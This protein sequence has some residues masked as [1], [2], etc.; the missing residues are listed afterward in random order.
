MHVQVDT[1]AYKIPR[2]IDKLYAAGGYQIFI[3]LENINS[4]NLEASKKRQNRIEDY[5]EMILA[6]KKYP[7]II[8]CGYIIGFPNDT[9]ES[10]LHDVEVLKR[11]L[12]IDNIYLNYLTPL[13]GSEDHKKLYEA[14]IWMDSGH[15]QIQSLGPRHSSSQDERRRLGMGLPGVS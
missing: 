10:V 7:T 8:T 2:F 3:G 12:A 14:G 13:P 6:W 15:E 9:V 4:D 1:M 11:D 5:R